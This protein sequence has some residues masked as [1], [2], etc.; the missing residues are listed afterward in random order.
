M[1]SIGRLFR[2]TTFGE[3][4]GSCVG[5]VIDGCPAGLQIDKTLIYD[6]LDRRKGGKVGTTARVEEDYPRFLSGLYEGITTGSPIAFVIDNVQSHSEDYALLE[7]VY[8]PSHADF[9]YQMKYGIR[10]P[11]GGGRSSARETVV[12]VV[13][14]GIATQIL[15]SVG[16]DVFAY[17]TQIGSVAMSADY[18]FGDR[19]YRNQS[20]TGCPIP[21]IDKRMGEA[22]AEAKGAGDSL[23]GIASVVVSGVPVGLGSPQYDKLDASLAAAM[24]GINACKGFEMGDGFAM[25][26]QR[27]SQVN[28]SFGVQDGAI[29]PMSNHSGGILGGI[30]DGAPILF[31]VAFKPIPSI[32][33]EQTTV[34]S[35]SKETQISIKGRHDVSVFPRVL[36]VIESMTALVLVDEILANRLVK[37][38]L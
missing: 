8:R 24:L 23:G 27:G 2:L 34:N 26:S 36:P 10:D 29:A 30:S 6:M 37:L 15:C 13:A 21:D 28:D 11:R 9:T 25:A 17:T 5:G 12:R 32:A 14:G 4:H 20:I 31:R 19:S 16:I 38:P 33:K 18:Y 1:N 22:L 7:D 3:S 35:A